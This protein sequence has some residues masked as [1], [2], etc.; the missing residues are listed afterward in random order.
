[1]DSSSQKGQTGLISIFKMTKRTADLTRRASMAAYQRQKPR[2]CR[3]F[4]RLIITAEPRLRIAREI[5]LM[6][7][8]ALTVAIF[9]GSS[10]H[11]RL[12]LDTRPASVSVSV[13]QSNPSPPLY[14]PP[15]P[16][17]P[18]LVPYLSHT[19]Q[20]SFSGTLP[21]SHSFLYLFHTRQASLSGTRP[22]MDGGRMP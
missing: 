22:P 13:C 10:L 8:A 15:P 1:M 18:T 12:T 16:P 20:S 2:N 14:P 6:Q 3:L 17:I 21:H 5:T 19:R 7:P 4:V 11:H 9:H